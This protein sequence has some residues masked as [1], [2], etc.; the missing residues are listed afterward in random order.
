[1]IYRYIVTIYFRVRLFSLDVCA[2]LIRLVPRPYSYSKQSSSE[3]SN[4]AHSRAL[5]E[6]FAVLKEIDHLDQKDVNCSPAQLLSLK[7]ACK[8]EQ[9]FALA[10]ASRFQDAFQGFFSRFINSSF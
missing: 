10:R 5:D 2:T 3:G 9:A 4:A 6:M 1:M 7:T 8:F